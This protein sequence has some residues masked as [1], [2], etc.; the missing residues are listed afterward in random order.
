MKEHVSSV[1][2]ASLFSK[3]I[4]SSEQFSFLNPRRQ[5]HHPSCHHNWETY[6]Q[7]PS[8]H[9]GTPGLTM[10]GMPISK[11]PSS[12]L[13]LSKCLPRQ[14]YERREKRPTLCCKEVQAGI[15]IRRALFRWR[16]RYCCSWTEGYRRLSQ[17]WSSRRKCHSSKQPGN[18]NIQP[19]TQ[20]GWI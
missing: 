5:Q 18:L 17:N 9:R 13:K 19:L 3:R 7:H 2:A 8:R 15:R 12:P 4:A 16:A 11:T 20:K 1:I 6:H 14:I 10:L